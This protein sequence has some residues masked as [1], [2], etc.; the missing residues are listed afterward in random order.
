M[1]NAAAPAPIRFTQEHVTVQS[2][3]RELGQRPSALLQKLT[4]SGERPVY[5][6]DLSEKSILG[7]GTIQKACKEAGFEGIDE[8]APAKSATI[9]KEEWKY[10]RPAAEQAVDFHRKY[11][12][13]LQEEVGKEHPEAGKEMFEFHNKYADSIENSIKQIDLQLRTTKTQETPENPSI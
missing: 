6:N 2:L 13:T 12:K 9:S 11:G 4:D 1:S 10:L 8:R 5:G 7:W 3:A